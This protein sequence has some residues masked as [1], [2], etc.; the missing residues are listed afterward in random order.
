MKT[1][2]LFKVILICIFILHL[3]YVEQTTSFLSL[4]IQFLPLSIICLS[5]FLKD[6]FIDIKSEVDRIDKS[7]LILIYGTIAGSTPTF[8]VSAK[9][10]LT[11]MLGLE[12]LQTVQV[13]LFASIVVYAVSLALKKLKDGKVF[14]EK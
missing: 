5:T 13:I 2:L 1:K 3:S 6:A 7:W 4:Y 9:V 14:I 10:F 12:Y 11:D 8:F